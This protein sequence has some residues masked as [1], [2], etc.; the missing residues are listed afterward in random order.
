MNLVTWSWAFVAMN[1]GTPQLHL[2]QNPS[3]TFQTTPSS[4]APTHYKD[5]VYG[6]S[7]NIRNHDALWL[8]RYVGCPAYLFGASHSIAIQTTSHFLSIT[9]SRPPPCPDP[10]AANYE[11]AQLQ[12]PKGTGLLSY[13]RP[14]EISAVWPHSQH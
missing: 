14:P 7:V 11:T 6:S 4:L 8:A 10:F 13:P 2:I 9:I 12:S 5:R 1:A 3:K